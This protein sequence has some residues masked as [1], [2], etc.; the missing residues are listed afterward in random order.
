MVRLDAGASVR[1]TS[2]HRIDLLAGALYADTDPDGT[3]GAATGRAPGEGLEIHTAAG[4]ARDVGTRFMTRLVA[5]ADTPTLQV[6]VRDGTVAVERDSDSVFAN[7]GEQV[8]ARAGAAIEL[9]PAA[10]FGPE[11]AWVIDSAPPFEVAGRSI[12]EILDWV[13]RET[14]WTVR[15]E[16]AALAEAA[17]GMIQESSRA[18][19]TTLR[20]DQ[21]HSALLPGANLEGELE[22]GVLTVR[23]Q[24]ADR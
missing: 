9:A 6:L 21:A 1:L 17:H 15:Y 7:A 24:R 14:G 16:D 18:L 10:T 3:R 20:P 19:T 13:A 22:A 5:G 4:V 2:P 8:V 12:A 11:W 23:R